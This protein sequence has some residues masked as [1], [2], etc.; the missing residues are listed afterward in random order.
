MVNGISSSQRTQ[1]YLLGFSWNFS[2]EHVDTR[3]SW[4]IPMKSIHRTAVQ[5]HRAQQS[6]GTTH[7]LSGGSWLGGPRAIGV[8]SSK[9]NSMV[10][11]V[12]PLLHTWKL[13]LDM[14]WLVY[15]ISTNDY[16][17][18]TLH[19]IIYFMYIWYTYSYTIYFM[20][21][22]RNQ[23]PIISWQNWMEYQ[24]THRI[25]KVCLAFGCPRPWASL[26]M[27]MMMMMMMMIYT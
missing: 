15:G 12:S 13:R 11:R 23:D 25:Q 22:H 10:T 5:S 6:G 7:R 20:Y 1:C 4:L 8:K 16:K 18:R 14:S 21:I 19:Y 17:C 24:I 27:M 9:A 26:L 2:V 3:H